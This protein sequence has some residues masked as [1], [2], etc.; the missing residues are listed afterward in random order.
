[1]PQL[2]IKNGR[3][4]AD[5]FGRPILCDSCPCG[6]IY[7]SIVYV[8]KYAVGNNDGT[9]WTDAYTDLQNA[10]NSAV[11]AKIYIK[12]YGNSDPYPQVTLNQCTW[13][14]GGVDGDVYTRGIIIPFI[15]YTPYVDNI[16]CDNPSGSYG[17]LGASGTIINCTASNC[18]YGF[19][20]MYPP[21]IITNCTADNCTYG[22]TGC[23]GQ[24]DNCTATASYYW[25]FSACNGGISNSSALSGGTFAE[26]FYN[27]SGNI[28]GCT[29]NNHRRGFYRCSGIITSSTANNN[30][31]WG[32]YQCCNPLNS[33]LTA[34][35]NGIGDIGGC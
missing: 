15:E 11:N 22:F 16:H 6:C 29:G 30:T 5:E 21:S 32:F 10:I 14:Q 3:P 25:G 18:I 24:I 9:S 33:G 28:S 2:W 12:G 4:V 19:S 34:S 1:M 26:G 7:T 35:G 27:I 8:D 20:T 31:E 13:I 23:N 17:F